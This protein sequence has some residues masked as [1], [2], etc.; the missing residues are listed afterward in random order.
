MADAELR[1]IFHLGNEWRAIDAHGELAFSLSSCEYTLEIA[2]IQRH[3]LHAGHAVH[4]GLVQ[5]ASRWRAGVAP[6]SAA[7]PLSPAIRWPHLSKRR[8]ARRPASRTITPP[9]GS[10][11]LAVMPA[12]RQRFGIGQH[13]VAVVAVKRHRIV[14]RDRIDVLARRQSWR[15]A[16]WSRPICRCGSTRPWASCAA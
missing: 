2:V 6:H 16:T 10:G 15:A 7:A 13:H 1:L 9:G 4:R 12:M 11:V 3:V 8:W 5:R 14:G